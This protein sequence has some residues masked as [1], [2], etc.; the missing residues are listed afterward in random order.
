[1]VVSGPPRSRTVGPR[2]RARARRDTPD[3]LPNVAWSRTRA[4]WTHGASDRASRVARRY[5]KRH[6]A[7][8][9]LAK[10]MR[11]AQVQ[12]GLHP[13]CVYRSIC[14]LACVAVETSPRY[15]SGCSRSRYPTFSV[16]GTVTRPPPAT[17]RSAKSNPA[18]P[19]YRHPSMCAEVMSMSRS[20]PI[21]P[22]ISTM[23]RMARLAASPWE[24]SSRARSSADSSR[25]TVDQAPREAASKIGSARST[26]SSLPVSE[27]RNRPGISTTAP[28]ST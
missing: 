13:I 19:W 5:P 10:K 8:H 20:A 12:V 11:D 21:T 7:T 14:R 26:I 1:M 15:S 16:E 6:T 2:A 17:S 3:V 4:A 25:G 23:I 22:A 9:D 24:P 27:M 18:R 28:G